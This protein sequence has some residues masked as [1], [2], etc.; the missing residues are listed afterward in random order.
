MN[1]ST[2]SHQPTAGPS[3]PSFQPPSNNSSAF[4][5]PQIQPQP[6]PQDNRVQPLEISTNASESPSF[7]RGGFIN[8]QGVMGGMNRP[9]TTT[10]LPIPARP[11]VHVPGNTPFKPL[12]IG[13]PRAQSTPIAH[14][15]LHANLNRNAQSSFVTPSRQAIGNPA[16]RQKLS[17]PPNAHV[18]PPATIPPST[19]NQFDEYTDGD[20]PD[21]MIGEGTSL[22]IGGGVDFVGTS[23]IVNE[24]LQQQQ[25]TMETP[26]RPMLG[27]GRYDYESEYPAGEQ[28]FR[29]G[30]GFTSAA[31]AAIKGLVPR[32]D[33]VP[34]QEDGQVSQGQ[35]EAQFKSGVG[36]GLGRGVAVD[37]VDPLAETEVTKLR[38]EVEQVRPEILDMQFAVG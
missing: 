10:G 17:P 16:K 37:V 4:R 18:P 25:Q 3:R 1:P 20:A 11:I 32:T 27:E 21:I 9:S 12:S 19:Y 7:T 28:D 34:S 8:R 30:P 29:F 35:G 24:R 33:F 23:Q 38:E 13:G 31:K 6:A 2:I 14:P 22:G 26:L 36:G 5:N 15:L